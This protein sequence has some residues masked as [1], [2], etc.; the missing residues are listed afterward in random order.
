ML[1]AL[2]TWGHTV[3]TLCL[4]HLPFVDHKVAAGIL[5]AC[6]NVVKFEFIGCGMTTYLEIARLLEKIQEVQAA[7]G[8][9][10]YFDAAPTFHKGCKW[11]DYL[12]KTGRCI[13]RRKGLF[14][15][16]S[17]DPGLDL[18][19]AILKRIVYELGPAA[20]GKSRSSSA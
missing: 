15:V 8:T 16:T 12:P 2:G 7:R 17:T 5:E 18:G 13:Y 1:R 11:D 9:C 6:P 4:K 20:K 10:I 3:R 19:P 14:G